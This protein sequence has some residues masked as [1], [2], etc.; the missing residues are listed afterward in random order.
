M[1]VRV[2]LPGWTELF[3]DDG[4]GGREG[5]GARSS[6]V[7]VC[8]PGRQVEGKSLHVLA[9]AAAAVKYLPRRRRGKPKDVPRVLP[10]RAALKTAERTERTAGRG[11]GVIETKINKYNIRRQKK[12]KPN[13]LRAQL[14]L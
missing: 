3:T 10:G 6:L 7:A 12:I 9:A 13:V 1:R 4:Y 5:G 14:L 2:G 11:D 8:P